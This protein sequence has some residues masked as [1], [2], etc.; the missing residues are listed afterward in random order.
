MIKKYR[1][2]KDTPEFK[3][4]SIFSF[5]WDYPGNYSTFENV[6]THLKNGSDR[7]CTYTVGCIKNALLE[8]GWFE[9]ANT[10]D[11]LFAE[12]K[13]LRKEAEEAV[14]KA[15]DLEKASRRLESEAFAKGMKE[16]MYA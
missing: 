7:H 9:S 6:A 15:K 8:G 5:D 12:S 4:G 14:K 16:V 3:A 10:A 2:L 13:R 1:L 11:E